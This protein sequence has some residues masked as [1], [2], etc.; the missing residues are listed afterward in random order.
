MSD[1][2]SLLISQRRFG[3]F[4]KVYN[5]N[6]FYIVSIKPREIINLHMFQRRKKQINPYSYFCLLADTTAFCIVPFILRN[7]QA[8]I[9][10]T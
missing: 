4:G 8:C 6:D 7:S 9:E 2:S 3:R 1:H 5:H 10:M